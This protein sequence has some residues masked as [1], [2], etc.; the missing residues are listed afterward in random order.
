M[1]HRIAS[2]KFPNHDVM[3]FHF[4]F[5]ISRSRIE[6]FERPLR[7]SSSRFL[8]SLG[9]KGRELVTRLMKTKGIISV[10]IVPYSVQIEKAPLFS[11]DELMPEIEAAVKGCLPE[12]KRDALVITNLNR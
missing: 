5:T 4:N 8:K 9:P 7:D 2:E 11:W 1:K 6:R 12:S 3:L 10:S